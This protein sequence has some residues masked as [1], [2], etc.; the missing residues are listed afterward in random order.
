MKISRYPLYK[1]RLPTSIKNGQYSNKS[2]TKK[3][4]RKSR[5]IIYLFSS[6]LRLQTGNGAII[7]Q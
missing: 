6:Y 1:S 3:L 7:L 4:Q 5:T 2:E